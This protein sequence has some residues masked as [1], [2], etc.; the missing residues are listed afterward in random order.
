MKASMWVALICSAFMMGVSDYYGLS[1]SEAV[2]WA[3]LFSVTL[4]S[5]LIFAL[6]E[7]EAHRR[8]VHKKV[9]KNY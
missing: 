4:G 5:L 9:N 8:G 1:N 3:I 7:Y 2:G 6:E